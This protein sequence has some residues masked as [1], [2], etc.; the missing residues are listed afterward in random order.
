MISNVI[1]QLEQRGFVIGKSEIPR[2]AGKQSPK[3][4][5]FAPLAMTDLGLRCHNGR[6]QLVIARSE[7]TKQSRV[8]RPR[9]RTE[10]ASIGR[11]EFFGSVWLKGYF[12]IPLEGNTE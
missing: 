7:A 9:M 12:G 3:R 5:C 2:S 8:Y 6:P 10:I 1:P 4:D 11:N